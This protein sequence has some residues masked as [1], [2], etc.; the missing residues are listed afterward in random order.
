MST[1]IVLRVP[2][3]DVDSSDRIHFTAMLRYM[4]MADHELLRTLGFPYAT[5]LHSIALPRVHVSCDY[6]GAVC[7]DDTIC[8]QA[9]VE[10]VGH[11]S[12][13]E[14]FVASLLARGEE[15]VTEQNVVAQGRMVIAVMN[16]Q[17]RQSM[18]IPQPLQAALAGALT[19]EGS[20]Q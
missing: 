18:P 12:W 10:R 16:P 5:L 2:F 14:T 11:R 6:R 3:P 20:D 9:H 1:R 8:V 19:E 7:Y 15:K 4:E 17:T 13:T